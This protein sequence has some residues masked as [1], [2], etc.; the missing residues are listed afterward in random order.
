MRIVLPNDPNANDTILL[1][2]EV[3]DE[4]GN[5]TTLRLSF[6]S[7]VS[8]DGDFAESVNLKMLSPQSKIAGQWLLDAP[9]QMTSLSS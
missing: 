2:S 5:I 3:I 6:T 8:L 7:E 4:Q 1:I 9:M